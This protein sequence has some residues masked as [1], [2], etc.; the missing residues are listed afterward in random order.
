MGHI[1]KVNP[2]FKEM[3]WGGHKLKDVYGY[4]IPSDHTGEFLLIRMEIVQ[5]RMEN[6]KEK[7]YHGYLKTIESYLG[8][9]KVINFLY[10]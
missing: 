5:L 4:D 8:I 1:L 9:L 10:W 2:V 3:I 7:L 6:L